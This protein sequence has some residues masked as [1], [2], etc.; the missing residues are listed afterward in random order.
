MIE[1]VENILSN[2]NLTA[3]LD[4]ICV[5]QGLITFMTSNITNS[6]NLLVN[7]HKTSNNNPLI[8]PFRIDYKLE[9]TWAKKN[10]IIEMF[11]KF[12]SDELALEFYDQIKSNRITI[13]LLQEFFFQYRNAD[14]LFLNIQNLKERSKS[15]Y[16]D[17]NSNY[18]Y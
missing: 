17:E 7:N 3:V 11:S 6:N 18:I 9:F 15:L 14:E 5:K 13:S 2:I 10:Q 12:Y 4:G 8:R 1:D 16:S